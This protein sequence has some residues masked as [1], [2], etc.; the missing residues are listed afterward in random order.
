MKSI[1]EE[2]KSLSPAW[3]GAIAGAIA[4]GATLFPE[5]RILGGLGAGAVVFFIAR[6]ASGP[7]CD[8][9]AAQTQQ[10]Q[11]QAQP[12]A[13]ALATDEGAYVE[14]TTIAAGDM[15]AATETDTATAIDVA[16]SSCLT[17]AGSTLAAVNFKESRPSPFT[18]VSLGAA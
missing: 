11:T 9:C 18:A 17:C 2:F 12:V 6:R 16:P 1:V 13:V 8:E 10:V 3:L 14:S 15:F 5:H 7:C 4:A